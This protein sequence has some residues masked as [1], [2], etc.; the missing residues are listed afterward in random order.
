MLFRSHDAFFLPASATGG[1]ATLLEQLQ[2]R[3]AT[4]EV[5]A[6][7]L[8]RDPT[9]SSLEFHA[10][11]GRLRQ[12][13]IVRDRL[14]QL[15][16]DDDQLEPRDILVMTPQVEAFAPL[17]GAVFGDSDATG[18]ALPWRLT[19]R[20]QQSE[21]G[22]SRVQDEGLIEARLRCSSKGFCF[23]LREDGGEDIYIRDNQLNHAWNGD[24]V[25]V[26]VTREGGL[27]NLRFMRPLTLNAINQDLADALRD[28]CHALAANK[29]VRAL[30]ISGEGR[31]FMAGGDIS[32]F[33][34]IGRAHV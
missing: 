10:C 16:A 19:D 20:S 11:P 27:M 21:A 4:G 23:A 18:V 8:H 29:D 1:A 9:D 12:L 34:E 2:E 3:L 22:I 31:S 6:G 13:Q 32:S 7:A 30:L 25:L 14:L 17:V 15:L 24:R 28:A 26:R 5:E 33:H